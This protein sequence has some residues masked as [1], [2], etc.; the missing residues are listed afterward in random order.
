MTPTT[1][2]GRLT[3]EQLNS[4][5]M[6]S[7]LSETGCA[8]VRS[9]REFPPAKAGNA[10]VYPSILMGFGIQLTTRRNNLLMF[11]HLDNHV[12]HPKLL[13]YWD[14]P[15]SFSVI[16][17]N[18]SGRATGRTTYR[19]QCLC[20][21]EER[22]YFLD[23]MPQKALLKSEATGGNMYLRGPDDR[24][25]SGAIQE[26]LV[27]LG[28]GHE[29]WTTS[30]FGPFFK[31]NADYLV[32]E[33]EHG[34]EPPPPEVVASVVKLVHQKH[35]VLRRDLIAAGFDANHLKWIVA[36]NLV[37][38]PIHEENLISEQCRFYVDEDA[39]LEEKHVRRQD[40]AGPPMPIQLSLPK[41]EQTI[42]WNG[43]TW[44][45]I[46]DGSPFTIR[47]SSGVLQDIALTDVRRYVDSKAWVYD[48]VDE[49]VCLRI[50][51]KRE[52]E[53]L[54]K[55]KWLTLPPGEARYT[56]GARKGMPVSPSSLA[57]VHR[58]VAHADANG[59]SRV[60]AVMN[61]YD[62][63]GDHSA[64]A[65]TP[66]IE[67]WNRALTDAYLKNHRPRFSHAYNVYRNYCEACN[68]QPK[69]ESVLRQ[70]LSRLDQCEIVQL[71]EGVF[72]AYGRSGYTP[73]S[74]TDWTLKGRL[75]WEVGHIDHSRLKIWLVSK[76]TG[77][78]I[79]KEAW[80]SVVRDACTFKPLG[81][82]FYFG[83]PSYETLYRLAI[84]IVKRWQQLPRFLI[85]DN[86]PDFKSI[87]FQLLLLR[88]G[89]IFLHRRTRMPRDGQPVELGFRSD[90]EKIIAN[91]P[92][93]KNNE[94]NYRSQQK[95]FR[96]KDSALFTLEEIAE[97]FCEEYYVVSPKFPSSRT[98]GE[99]IEDFEARLLHE[100]GTTHIRP[101]TYDSNFVF[102][103]MPLVENGG[104][105]R[106]VYSDGSVEANTL[107]YFSEEFA[108][109][110]LLGTEVQ[111]RYDPD[112]CARVLAWGE[113][114]HRWIECW[115]K[116][117]RVLREFT[118]KEREEI[119]AR[120]KQSDKIC[121]VDSRRRHDQ[122]LA[123]AISDMRGDAWLLKLHDRARQN[124]PKIDGFVFKDGAPLVDIP[125]LPTDTP[126]SFSQDIEKEAERAAARMRGQE[127]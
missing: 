101:V 31:G 51:P 60:L 65:D 78:L 63:C 22:V 76:V 120:I 17:K 109:Y 35:V 117:Y 86:G 30:Q 125:D 103:S 3:D 28:I 80:R 49:P 1:A 62:N 68:V 13:E 94:P 26:R 4:V 123:Q 75:P 83:A 88:L 61:H 57:R 25:F 32:T 73:N 104:G 107:K 33:F 9:V 79:E 127:T 82:T 97:R 48:H 2:V 119:S 70:R 21:E 43:K 55:L 118:N 45:V 36:H 19:P 111:V 20:I 77:E 102:W 91:L 126:N 112:N 47:S 29:I 66:E 27:P 14:K 115:C 81:S 100:N 110:G 7:R 71:R 11:V 90:I 18:A 56:F 24:W 53:A 113:N 8:L 39:Y 10:G 89:V 96:P 58:K 84:D 93:S 23:L 34:R 46:N 15:L 122:V 72:V 54:E 40:G 5:L 41:R 12:L 105:V 64:T 106:F 69:A 95:G 124:F 87:G 42:E 92:G 67:C 37:F 74:E 38:F 108:E 121:K 116:E 99:T 59:I 50:S 98:N 85:S 6:R 52:F 44:T 16:F 114:I